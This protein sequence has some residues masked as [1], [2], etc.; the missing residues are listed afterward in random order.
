MIDF[1]YVLER[2]VTWTNYHETLPERVV[3]EWLTL[4]REPGGPPIMEQQGS[5]ISAIVKSCLDRGERL[6]MNGRGWSL[7][8]AFDP[9]KVVLDIGSVN[10]VFRLPPVWFSTSYGQTRGPKVPIYVGGGTQIRMLN[11]EL[12]QMGLA[13]QTSGASDGHRMAGCIGTGTHGADLKV[14]AAHDTVIALCLVTAPGKMVVLQPSSR[15]LTSGLGEWLGKST[16]L[17]TETVYDDN[18]FRA[19][20]VALGGLGVVY[21]M[22]VETVPLYEIAGVDY[23]KALFDANIWQLIESLDTGGLGGPSNADIVGVVALPYAK[24]G[25][26]GAYASVYRKQQR[27]RE[28]HGPAHVS[29]LIATDTSKLISKMSHL[30]S[31]LT[32]PL[33][34]K[35]VT[36]ISQSAFR[37]GPV[38]PRFPGEM[39]GPTSL[40]P[41]NGT[42]SEVILPQKQAGLALRTLLGALTSEANQGRHLF[43]V[44]G[45]RFT[46]GSQAHLALNRDDKTMYVEIAGVKSRDARTIHE[47]C[48]TALA[49][50][51][52]DFTCHWGQEYGMDA[53]RVDAYYGARADAWRSARN[54]LLDTPG[55]RAT[56]TTPLLKK[57]NLA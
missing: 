36:A 26:P 40:P 57:L 8:D 28:Y 17:S 30:D 21:G 35:V 19:A 24:P 50:E 3:E 43:G 53:A 13:L 45:I 39:F 31:A 20:Q 42:C 52:V 18:L 22:V 55:A 27:R 7:S 6:S 46:G 48:W 16:K 38:T 54:T 5:A 47:A 34:G 23:G 2:R 49:N 4:A 1:R 25:E 37:P 29:S 33:I 51:G 44:L 10:Q 15:P 41:G 11:D 56:F 9:D 14:G 12:G 32:G